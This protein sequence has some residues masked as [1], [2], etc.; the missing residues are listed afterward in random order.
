MRDAV[1]KDSNME[2][3]K[4]QLNGYETMERPLGTSEK[5]MYKMR[6]YG[7]MNVCAVVAI[8]GEIDSDRLRRALSY[9]VASNPILGSIAA[10]EKNGFRDKKD[11]TEHL[12]FTKDSNASLPFSKRTVC[13]EQALVDLMSSELTAKMPD[14]GKL[15][16]L[17]LVIIEPELEKDKRSIHLVATF[18]HTII[19]GKS[20]YKF[21]ESLLDAYESNQEDG[22]KP[23]PII[24]VPAEYFTRHV[25]RVSDVLRFI[26]HEFSKLIRP[27]STPD[28]PTLVELPKRNTKLLKISFSKAESDRLAEKAREKGTTV[29]GVIVAALVFSSAKHAYKPKKKYRFCNATPVDLRK[30]SAIDDKLVGNYSSSLETMHDFTTDTTFWSLAQEVREKVVSAK[31]NKLHLSSLI[32]L[33]Y[34][35]NLLSDGFRLGLLNGKPQG[36]LWNTN[37]SNLGVI[38]LKEDYGDVSIT[39]FSVTTAQHG[40]GAC[41]WLLPNTFNGVLST[42]LHYVDPLISRDKASSVQE[43]MKDLMVKSLD[44]D[45]TLGEITR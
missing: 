40:F 23:A 24:S 32:I 29:L 30:D 35:Q 16:R 17:E 6:D 13:S 25:L 19:D 22:S 5:L 4:V 37:V 21:F 14:D 28:F 15:W 3:Q 45:F 9:V 18:D 33:R 42:Y 31:A 20:T 43:S 1:L 2:S 27:F 44:T 41:F 26:T 39:D 38:D 34:L 11:S 12:R 10:F 36:R 8:D 7:G